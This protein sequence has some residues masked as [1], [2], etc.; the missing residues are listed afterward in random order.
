MKHLITK[1]DKEGT[2]QFEPIMEKEIPL[3]KKTC[4]NPCEMMYGGSTRTRLPKLG[5]PNPYRNPKRE[6]RKKSVKRYY[7]KT[8]HDRPQLEQNQN[9][10]FERK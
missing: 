1:C 2:D 6:E 5:Q 9:V 10:F 8:A 4:L 3:E 7:D